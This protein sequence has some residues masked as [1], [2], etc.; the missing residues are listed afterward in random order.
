MFKP[1]DLR[2]YVRITVII[3]IFFS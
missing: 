2:I 3:Y 1:F